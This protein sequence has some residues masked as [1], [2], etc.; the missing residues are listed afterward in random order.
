MTSTPPRRDPVHRPHRRVVGA[1]PLARRGRL[2]RGD[3]RGVRRGQPRRVA[4][5][6]AAPPNA[7]TASSSRRARRTT[8]FGASGP[9]ER[10]TQT[11]Y[12]VMSSPNGVQDPAFRAAVADAVARLSDLQV[13]LDGQAQPVFEEVTDPLTAPPQAGL[14]SPDGTTVR[15]IARASAESPNAEARVAPVGPAIEEIQAAHP[16]FRI[17]GLSGTLANE[18][19][20]EIV[21]N[22]L[23]G[24]LRITIP[25][26]FA[27]L[28][29]AF[30]ALAA[31][32]VPLVLAVTA[33]LAAFGVLALYSQ[34]VNPTSPYAAPAGRADRAR[35]RG[36]L[37]AVH[38]QPLPD[39]APR[40]PRERR[41]HP[42]RVG[43]GR[44]R[45]VLQRPRGH[46]LDR[47]P[48]PPRRPALPLDG[49]R[50]D[51][52]GGDLGRRLAHLPAGG[53]GHPRPAHRLG[54]DPVLR[55][56][57]TGGQ[58]LLEPD[59]PRRH[60]PPGRLRRRRRRCCCSPSPP[61][62]RGSISARATSRRSRTRSTRSRRSGS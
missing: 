52:G 23:D 57:A 8:V 29:V 47:G 24:S 39:R 53:D 26:T 42:D 22:D 48:V 60:A 61:R 30:G 40:R 59:R 46:D 21:S 55:P 58:W 56:P 62:Q 54:P 36:R 44:S 9:T 33:L 15:V 3:D 37:L 50:D 17:H 4:P 14:V 19:I 32:I 35:G 34:F 12:L 1:P 2:V 51:R 28:L 49:G 6:P 13:T 11:V 5:R 20:S 7:R 27:I 10:P 16:A 45:R 18:Q 31:A 43:H 41:R 38:D 25:L